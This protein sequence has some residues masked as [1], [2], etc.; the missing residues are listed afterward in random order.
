MN[1]QLDKTCLWMQSGGNY[2]SVKTR[3]P[4]HPM[5]VGGR[6]PGQT[7]RSSHASSAATASTSA[8]PA[9]AYHGHSPGGNSNAPLQGAVVAFDISKAY[10]FICP[11][12]C[13]RGHTSAGFRSASAA[14]P[15]ATT[16]KPIMQRMVD[17]EAAIAT[18]LL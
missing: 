10:S 6:R 15:V 8:T 1:L 18:W 13:L 11:A 14:S 5:A 7:L 12:T 4:E 16:S 17:R 2:S 3:L 9:A